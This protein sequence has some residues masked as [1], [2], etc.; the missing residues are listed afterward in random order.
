MEFDLDHYYLEDQNTILIRVDEET[1]NNQK[2][3]NL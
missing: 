1:I 2:I 3:Q